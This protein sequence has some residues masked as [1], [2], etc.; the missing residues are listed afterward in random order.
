MEGCCEET[1]LPVQMVEGEL[2]D[3]CVQRDNVVLGPLGTAAKCDTYV[4]S[5]L[6]DGMLSIGRHA[7]NAGASDTE[8]Y[9]LSIL[10]DDDDVLP[11][12]NMLVM[13]IPDGLRL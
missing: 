8:Q 2:V 11:E 5:S 6:Y 4:L 9:P 7:F 10:N 12:E 13:E 3:V 1:S